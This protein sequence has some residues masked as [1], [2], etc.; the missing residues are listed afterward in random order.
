MPN[1]KETLAD[2]DAEYRELCTRLPTSVDIGLGAGKLT[3]LLDRVH[4]A[5]ERERNHLLHAI[6]EA[7]C[8]F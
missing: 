4:A 6:E 7:A 5:W 1:D 2:I 3:E 8:G